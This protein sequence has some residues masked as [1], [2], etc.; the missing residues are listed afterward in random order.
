MT[1]ELS[2]GVLNNTAEEFVYKS[3][4]SALSRLDWKT[5][6]AAMF[7]TH[8]SIYVMPWLALGLK[9]ATNLNGAAKLD[10]YDFDV[11]GCPVSSAGHTECHSNSATTLRRAR[12]L[13]LYGSAQIV[14]FGGVTLN[15]LAG[16]KSD[17]YRWQAFGGTANYLSAPSALP[18]GLGITYEQTWSA[19]Y[20]GLGGSVQSGAWTLNGRVV[21]SPF[22]KGEDRD[23]HHLRSLT[24]TENFGR[25]TYIGADLGLGYR[26]SPTTTLTL[27]YNYQ[28]WQTAKGPITASIGNQ[29]Y[30]VF[31]GDAGGGNNVSHMVNLGLKVDLSKP[32]AQ[33]GSTKDDVP[34]H[35]PPVWT[36]WSAGL[37]SGP[38]WLRAHWLTTSL[39]N[40]A[41]QPNSSSAAATLSDSGAR[42][43]G[44]A[45][46]SWQAGSAVL[47]IEADLGKS[48]TSA[49]HTGIP[50]VGSA[51]IQPFFSDSVMATTGWDGSLRGRLGA[52]INPSLMLYATGGLALQQFETRVSCPGA[53]GTISWC[54]ADR[55]EKMGKVKAG[56]TLGA[57]YESLFAGNW[58]TR[59]EYRYSN[60]GSSD[61]VFFAN[62]PLDTVSTKFDTSSHRLSFGLGY[63]F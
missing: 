32:A 37:T 47:G 23:Q 36:G 59:G 34:H 28:N 63:R 50:G 40:P 10:D 24:F 39:E 48:N 60:F 58:F 4:G 6:N 41:V 42:V 52:V 3:N 31:Q 46:Y 22:A 8:T 33:E 19:P 11:L 57:G 14:K 27:N 30:A 45:G 13:D 61:Q 62:A 26:L 56:Y 2:I 44:F 15:A 55:D 51:A 29:Q 5:S 35:R 12:L 18:P 7:N 17:Y 1:T 53:S 21:G 25:S 20:L 16:Y 54:L 43:G 49:T 38:E 9:G